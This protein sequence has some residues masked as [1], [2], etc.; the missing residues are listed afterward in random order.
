MRGIVFGMV[1]LFAT[2]AFGNWYAHTNQN[3]LG[4]KF[5][6]ATSGV[7]KTV[8]AHM[9]FPYRDSK[10]RILVTCT[11]VE[12]RANPGHLQTGWADYVIDS[13]PMDNVKL[14]EHDS[15]LSY[16]T[17]KKFVK[18]LREGSSITVRLPWY[19]ERPIFR[20]SLSGSSA[21]LD[22]L[23]QRCGAP[24]AVNR[25]CFV[26]FSDVDK[27]LKCHNSMAGCEADLKSK[28]LSSRCNELD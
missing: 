9:D 5:H 10:V 6:Y 25:Y 18:S 28:G 15:D 1:M 17:S 26:D 4:E 24:I 3:A 8:D 23:G 14:T 2:N 11:S 27:T 12:F 19:Q 20:W 7:S 13:K 21:A 16:T 22:D